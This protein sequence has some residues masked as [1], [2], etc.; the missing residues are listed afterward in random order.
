MALVVRNP[1]VNAG[2]VRDMSSIPGSGRSPGGG[3]GNP[4]QDSRLE[5]L[6]DR[7]A[8]W[9]RVH[10]VSQSGTRQVI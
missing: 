2:D 10:R 8:W 7:G 5:N 9:A 3:P 6:T 1:P 4:L